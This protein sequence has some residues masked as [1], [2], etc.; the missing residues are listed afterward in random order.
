ME[1]TEERPARKDG[2][3]FFEISP[4]MNYIVKV[5]KL[6]PGVQKKEGRTYTRSCQGVFADP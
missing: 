6:L 5:K 1:G 4:E 3:I 2:G